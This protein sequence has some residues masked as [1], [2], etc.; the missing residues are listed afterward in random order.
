MK[1]IEV[2]EIVNAA[3]KANMEISE[4]EVEVEISRDIFDEKIKCDVTIWNR[5]KKD[6]QRKIIESL[7]SISEI[8][9]EGETR[10]AN[11]EDLMNL[12]KKYTNIS[13]R[14]GNDE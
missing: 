10:T 12:I 14:S 4:F 3:M 8:E 1:R 13:E 5:Y 7:S 9:E 2:L 6:T 11:A